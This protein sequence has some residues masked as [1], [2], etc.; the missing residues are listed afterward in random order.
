MQAGNDQPPVENILVITHGDF[1]Y[2]L[3]Y[4]QPYESLV[5]GR[6]FNVFAHAVGLSGQYRTL[7]INGGVIENLET[8][9]TV[10][11]T[12]ESVVSLIGSRDAIF[13]Y[14][15]KSDGRLTAIFSKIASHDSE[16]ISL[17]GG[18]RLSIESLGGFVIIPE[19]LPSKPEVLT[20][21]PGR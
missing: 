7:G 5:F 12:S 18:Q 4:R 15:R 11:W 6:E 20:L 8:K 19:N 13:E 10:P 16:N 21:P 2:R 3:E 14:Y 1:G 17:V 9:A